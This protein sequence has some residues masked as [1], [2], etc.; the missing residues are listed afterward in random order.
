MPE[1]TIGRPF[2]PGVSGNP[3]GRPKEFP[4]FRRRLLENT[5]EAFDALM[6]EVRAG[7][8]EALKVFFAYAFGKPPKEV[9]ITGKGGGALRIGVYDFSKLSDEKV[10]LLESTLAEVVVNEPSES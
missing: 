10:K 4:D 7:S 1:S 6:A 5:D 2:P 9:Q 8:I 3:G